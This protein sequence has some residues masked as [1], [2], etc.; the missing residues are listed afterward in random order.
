MSI[1]ASGVKAAV[2]RITLGTGRLRLGTFAVVT[3][4]PAASAPKL[5]ALSPPAE[6]SVTLDQLL[7]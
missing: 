7:L 5:W 1:V 4:A 2:S 3:G 6:I